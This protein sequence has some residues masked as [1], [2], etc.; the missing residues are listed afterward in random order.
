MKQDIRK[1]TCCILLRGT[2]YLVGWNYFYH[3]F[4]WSKSY[5]DAWRTRDV[6]IAVKLARRIGATVML[7]NPIVNQLRPMTEEELVCRN[8]KQKQR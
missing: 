4:N 1:H 7:F 8:T 6:C 3:D 5:Y 2:D